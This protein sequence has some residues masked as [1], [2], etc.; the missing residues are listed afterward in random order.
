MLYSRNLLP[1][2]DCQPLRL[3]VS[4][5]PVK[6]EH[7]GNHKFLINKHVLLFGSWRSGVPQDRD[8][9]EGNDANISQK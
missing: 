6:E 1:N 7:S 4:V 2:K 9:K 5:L 3:A 8:G